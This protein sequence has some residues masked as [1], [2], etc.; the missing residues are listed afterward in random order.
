MAEPAAEGDVLVDVDG[1]SVS[2][3]VTSPDGGA[4]WAT[5]VVAPG[6]GAGMDHPFLVG[7]T[8][9]LARE[10]LASMRFNFV[11][12]E[13]G[14]RAPDRPPKAIA[15]WRAAREAA[16][17]WGGG[18][19]WAAGKSFGGRM[20]SMA[21]AEGMAV[22]GLVYLGYPLHPPGRPDKLRAAHLDGIRVPQVFLSGSRDPFVQPTA[23]LSEIVGRLPDARLLWVEGARHS[24]EVARDRR[25]VLE[26]GASLAPA[27]ADFIAERSGRTAERRD[28]DVPPSR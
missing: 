24:F 22:A 13:Q 3:V 16:G 4:P 18:P 15:A 19:V 6:A 2:A 10:G 28:R 26:V 9:G 1:I 5:V 14:R 25:S 23:Q 17:R 12:R 11:Y 21:A 20:A 8:R 7:F 27:V